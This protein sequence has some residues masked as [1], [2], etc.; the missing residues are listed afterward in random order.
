MKTDDIKA[1]SNEASIS[2]NVV[3]SA[4]SG[5]STEK[6]MLDHLKKKYNCNFSVVSFNA[7]TV[8]DKRY[9]MVA[10]REDTTEKK[11]EMYYYPDKKE[12]EQ[13]R[14]TYFSIW[15]ED[16]LKSEFEKRFSNVEGQ[17]MISVTL[18]NRSFTE[19][20]CSSKDLDKLKNS[21]DKVY[22]T[23][24]YFTD[25]SNAASDAVADL[26]EGIYAKGNVYLYYVEDF[27]QITGKSASSI[28]A[29]IS[30]NSIGGKLIEKISF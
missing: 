17:K 21:S 14:D 13:F 9:S 24:Y 23:V 22:A 20:F 19:S 18:L 1:V 8:L 6:M 16:D 29:Q 4:D 5:N 3:E 11:F 26:T 7:E 25:N 28:I 27:S 2:K 10:R 12:G 15:V 30:S